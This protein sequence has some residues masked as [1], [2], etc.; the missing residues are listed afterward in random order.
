MN[1]TLPLR[2]LLI[3]FLFLLPHVARAT[4]VVGQVSTFGDGTT[5]GWAIN[6]L[7]IGAPP[8]AVLPKNVPNGGPTGAGDPFLLLNSL[9]GAGGGSRLAAL[10]T[11]PE[12]TG[13]YM[14]AGV[15]AI[16]MDLFNVGQTDLFLRL[17]FEDPTIGPPTNIAFSTDAVLL[18]SGGAWTA[19]TFPIAPDDL[20][21]ALGTVEDALSSTTVLRLYHSPAPNVP[22]PIA[23]IPAIVAS[24]GVDNIRALGIAAVPE[25]TTLILL[26]AGL[27]VW[28][29]SRARP[30][31][32]TAARN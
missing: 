21:A 4:P 14:S 22:N 24:L 3:A 30:G 10:N 25:P 13:N 18:P 20:T 16:T 8:A 11:A 19:V 2:P 23:P 15:N 32:N 17:A 6:L 29:A 5:Q 27:L 9:G 31:G 1:F 28:R 7:G 26:A 12:W